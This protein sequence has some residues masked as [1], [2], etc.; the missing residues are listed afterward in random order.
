MIDHASFAA[1]ARELDLPRDVGAITV[2]PRGIARRRLA[3]GPAR[4]LDTR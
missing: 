1:I 2:T 4:W 3:T